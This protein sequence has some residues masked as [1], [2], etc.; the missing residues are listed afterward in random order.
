M[1]S[2]DSMSMPE[3]NELLRQ[4]EATPNAGQCNHG[5]PAFVIVKLDELD[6][7]FDR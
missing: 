1:R 6:K 3:M 4:V 7:L 5:R 2:G